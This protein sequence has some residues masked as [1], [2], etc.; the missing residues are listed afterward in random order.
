MPDRKHIFFVEAYGEI[1]LH[2]RRRGGVGGALLATL[3][4]PTNYPRAA[5]DGIR[6][7][8]A[9]DGGRESISGAYRRSFADSGA[10]GARVSTT[11]SVTYTTQDRAA[12]G[13]RGAANVNVFNIETGRQPD[14]QPSPTTEKRVVAGCRQLQTR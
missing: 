2:D 10:F 14:L 4:P 7:T 1:A 5:R 8:N 13:G 6:P 12:I 9:P 11:P 3:S